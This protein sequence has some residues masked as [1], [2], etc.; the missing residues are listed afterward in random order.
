MCDINE[1]IY[2][3]IND[4]NNELWF[5]A[6]HVASVIGFSNTRNATVNYVKNE[7]KRSFGDLKKNNF[8]SKKKLLEQN[9]TF[10][11]NANGLESLIK[12]SNK[13]SLNEKVVIINHFNTKFGD[14]LNFKNLKNSENISKMKEILSKYESIEYYKVSDYYVDLYFPI[15]K[16]AVEFRNFE[17]YNKKNKE[18]R[19]KEIINTLKCD[20]IKFYS[21]L[22]TFSIY[23]AIGELYI[24]IKN[25]QNTA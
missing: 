4:E 24:F 18:N 7:D 22:E 3:F 20:Y 8:Y 19:E 10:F 9:F 5:K 17:Y 15:L 21:Q 2:L 16:I 23:E 6:K 11:V 13:I 25:K 1:I 14:I 12:K